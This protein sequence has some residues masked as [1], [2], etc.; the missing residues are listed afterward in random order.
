MPFANV[1]DWT[2]AVESPN[3]DAGLLVFT[4]MSCKYERL[5]FRTAEFKIAKHENNAPDFH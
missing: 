2:S 3:F 4:Q 1:S 5:T